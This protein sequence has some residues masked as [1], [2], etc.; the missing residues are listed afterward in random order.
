[1]SKSPKEILE[2]EDLQRDVEFL[3]LVKFSKELYR[4]NIH[5]VQ[6]NKDEF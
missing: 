5:L 4:D 6:E 2:E 3:E 1:M